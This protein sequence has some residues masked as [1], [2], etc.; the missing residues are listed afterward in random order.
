MTRE[1]NSDNY[2]QACRTPTAS[3]RRPTSP[4]TAMLGRI[5][6]VAT[7]FPLSET[8]ASHKAVEAGGKVGTVVVEPQR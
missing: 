6:S 7:R 4:W 5:L 3:G 2:T 8:A 1:H